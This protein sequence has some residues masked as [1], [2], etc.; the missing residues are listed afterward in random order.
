MQVYSNAADIRV[1]DDPEITVVTPP[2]G[3]HAVFSVQTTRAPQFIDITEAV[4]GLLH[5]SGL[6]S[7]IAVVTS[8]HTTASVKLNENEPELLKDMEAF[9]SGI[10]PSDRYYRHNDF[11]VR[12]VNVEEDECPNAH[13]HCQHLLLNAS[14]SV[15]VIDGRLMLGRWQRLFL[16]ELDRP[17]SRNIVVSFVGSRS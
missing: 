17:R 13:S 2:G 15:P 10:A 4:R 11:S 12:T 6:E 1:D 5:E 14:E 8:Q 7:G 16:V 9:L 3:M